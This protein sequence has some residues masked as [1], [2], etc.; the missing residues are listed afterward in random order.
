MKKHILVFS[1]VAVSALLLI[2]WSMAQDTGD[3]KKIHIVIKK[4]V[5]GEEKTFDKVYASKEEMM[6][7]PELKAFDPEFVRED[8]P[9][10][11]RFHSGEGDEVFFFEHAKAMQAHEIE[12]E[13]LEDHLA[14]ME[15]ELDSMHNFFIFE[16]EGDSAFEFH[17]GGSSFYKKIDAD[18]QKAIHDKM[19]AA[20]EFDRNGHV[21]IWKSD[22]VNKYT[23]RAYGDIPMEMGE[24]DDFDSL[25]AIP[26]IMFSLPEIP[27][28]PGIPGHP[29]HQR[30]GRVMVFADK[31]FVI[32][33]LEAKDKENKEFRSLIGK[34]KDLSLE[35]LN[36]YPNPSD[37]RFRLRFK[38]IEGKEL[39]ISIFD[40][41]G[42]E[43]YTEIIGNFTG[44]Y[45]NDI[46]ISMQP[47]GV[48]L[49]QIKQ[50]GK[51]QNK[52]L[53]ID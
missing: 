10:H 39:K 29:K 16:G 3:K 30:H 18:I 50:D 28:I 2:S 51:A 4:D 1:L 26:D 22:S 40:F 34:S 47:K 53:V 20:R 12:M 7:D 15:G 21:M 32:S 23:F 24:L 6:N 38:G 11:F 36:Y 8:G 9:G 49:L 44:R 37:G 19:K 25:I 35:E 13:K 31:N 45:D 33:E 41:S 43:V 48:Y 5:N 52:K 17:H 46:S 14:I 42:K 27:E